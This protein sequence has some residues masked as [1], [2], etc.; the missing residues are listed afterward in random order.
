MS[1]TKNI[2]GLRLLAL[3]LAVLAWFFFNQGTR[4][5]LSDK[6]VEASLRYPNYP[7]LVI[8]DRVERVRVGVRGPESES[9]GLN[10]FQV[11]VFVELADPAVGSFEVFLGFENVSLPG[12]LEVVSIEPQVI[13]VRVDR[14]V[15]L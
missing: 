2:W 4:E 11:D 15:D 1:E 14:R 9:S 10:P 12:N 7:N 8:L 5:H 3:A 13:P 6:V